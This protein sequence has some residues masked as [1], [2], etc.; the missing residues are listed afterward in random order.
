M[1]GGAN[2]KVVHVVAESGST[3][4]FYLEKRG[5]SC[6]SLLFV[7]LS[8]HKLQIGHGGIGAS[9][10]VEMEMNLCCYSCSSL[11]LCPLPKEPTL[12]NS[13]P[14]TF[15]R[16]FPQSFPQRSLTSL[17]CPYPFL[18]SECGSRESDLERSKFIKSTQKKKIQITYKWMETQF[19][20]NYV[21]YMP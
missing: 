1:H 19:L 13:H 15:S 10:W 20:N 5:E 17:I 12:F 6:E 2:E 11:S 8:N 21:S 4:L 9:A 7:S 16:C 3:H 18:D 14:S